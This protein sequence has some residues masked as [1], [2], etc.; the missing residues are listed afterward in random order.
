MRPADHLPVPI[1][2]RHAFFAQPCAIGDRD[3]QAW[4]AW[5]QR[6]GVHYERKDLPSDQ[7]QLYVHRVRQ[8]ETCEGGRRDVWCCLPVPPMP[9]RRRTERSR[10]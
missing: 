10:R 1:D 9:S 4:E 8:R 7:F 6:T 5:F 3:A 2:S